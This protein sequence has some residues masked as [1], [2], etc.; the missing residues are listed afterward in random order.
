MS[1]YRIT[2][3]IFIEIVWTINFRFVASLL[4]VCNIMIVIFFVMIGNICVYF[5]CGFF[6]Y[7]CSIFVFISIMFCFGVGFRVSDC[8]VFFIFCIVV[9]LYDVFLSIFIVVFRC[10]FVLFIIIICLFVCVLF[11]CC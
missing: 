11:V 1:G 7:D 6:R 8:V 5:E 4:F 9:I 3:I 2:F 10:V